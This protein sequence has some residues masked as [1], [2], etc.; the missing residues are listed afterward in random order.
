MTLFDAQ[1]PSNRNHS[2]WPLLIVMG[3]AGITFYLFNE[4]Y[5][6]SYFTRPSETT[7]ATKPPEPVAR[8]NPAAP[9][10]VDVPVLPPTPIP[11]PPQQPPAETTTPTVVEQPTIA[12]PVRL[13]VN[14]DIDGADVFVD[15]QFVGKT[16]FESREIA[17]GQHRINV[18]AIDFEGQVVDVV[19]A[20]PEEKGFN[21]TIVDIKFLQ[22]DI[23]SQAAVIHKHRFG[24][25][26]G[27]LVA[28]LEGLRYETEGDDAFSIHYDQLQHFQ[29]DYVDHNLQ[30]KISSGRTYN[31]TD[32]MNNADALFVF[33]RD[34][35]KA[36]A[37]LQKNTKNP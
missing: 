4:G 24:N 28:N 35:E 11:D 8:P 16:P 32:E 25:C 30:I 15:R 17:P 34:V 12:I 19:I 36:R 21:S 1:E 6:G 3:L 26:E 9:P 22:I 27:T 23:D 31:F 18:S 29:I 2:W 7:V 14:A 13:L 20:D 37:S 33:H 5:F 10:T